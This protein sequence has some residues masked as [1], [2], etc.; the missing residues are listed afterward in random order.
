MHN[1][2]SHTP[3]PP[4]PPPHLLFALAGADV[5]IGSSRGGRGLLVHLANEALL[6]LDMEGHGALGQLLD[7]HGVVPLG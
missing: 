3:L 1:C 6:R 7:A 4:A 5:L 2:P